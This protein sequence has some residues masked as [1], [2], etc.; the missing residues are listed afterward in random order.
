MKK[1]TRVFLL[2][3][4]PV[5]LFYD[6]RVC[7]SHMMFFNSI[8]MFN[9]ICVCVCVFFRSLLLLSE[10]HSFICEDF[11]HLLPRGDASH[12]I[13][14]LI[15]LLKSCFNDWLWQGPWLDTD[16]RFRWE[17]KK[18]KFEIGEFNY[19]FIK[20]SFIYEHMDEEDKWCCVLMI[21]KN[22]Y[23]FFTIEFGESKWWR[24]WNVAKRER[25][26]ERASNE[27]K[28]KERDE[29]KDDSKWSLTWEMLSFF[30][31]FKVEQLCFYLK[32]VNP[33][34]KSVIQL[35]SSFFILMSVVLW[36]LWSSLQFKN[37]KLFLIS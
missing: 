13:F 20:L 1:K 24:C 5:V 19:R 9:L 2:N 4:V 37:K 29:G 33:C 17:R 28:K 27:E 16:H 15:W 36:S 14:R 30:N 31:I 21:E 7:Y 26:R 10:L 6:A 32:S 23:L 8:L 18:S 3:Y 35:V 25:E 34:I 11:V 12:R 22:I